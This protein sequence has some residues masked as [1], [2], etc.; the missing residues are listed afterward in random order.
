MA[1]AAKAGV[2][3]VQYLLEQKADLNQTVYSD[4]ALHAACIYERIDNLR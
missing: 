1:A 3:L 4:S 2:D